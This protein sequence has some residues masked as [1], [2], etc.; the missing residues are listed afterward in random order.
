MND[1]HSEDNLTQEKNRE[2]QVTR[3][4]AAQSLFGRSVYAIRHWLGDA[5]HEY[6]QSARRGTTAPT[7]RYIAGTSDVDWLGGGETLK[8]YGLAD[9]VYVFDDESR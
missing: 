4:K 2:I 8:L 6:T 1:P 3:G 5:R 9:A 7:V